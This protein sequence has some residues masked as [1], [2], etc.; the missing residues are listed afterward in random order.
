[1][2]AV[3]RMIAIATQRE[4]HTIAKVLESAYVDDC[5]C[6]VATVQEL[7]EIKEHMPQFMQEHGFPTKALACTGEAAPQE[8]SDTGF[9]NTAGYSR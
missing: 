6:S 9:I 5:N 2:A 3:K 4:L 7:K 8:L 1:M